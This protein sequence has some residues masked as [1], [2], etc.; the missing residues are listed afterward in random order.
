MRAERA[1]DAPECA[2]DGLPTGIPVGLRTA[3]DTMRLG[4]SLAPNVYAGC[5][6][7]LYGRIGAGKTTLV[8]GLA[9]GLG[10][11][12]AAQSP[13]FTIVAEYTGGR[14][15]LYHIDL[16]RLEEDAARELDMLDEY[17]YGE[18]VCAVEWAGWIE[19]ALPADRLDIFLGDG[20]T[21]RGGVGQEIDIPAWPSGFAGRE[22]VPRG[23]MD[24]RI[25]LL[26]ATG[27][28]SSDALGRWWGAWR[29]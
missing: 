6:V 27:A 11:P 7:A 18:G 26:R 9:H 21:V 2:A 4:E 28:R 22:D 24:S 12:A 20:G 14:L 13:T 8:Q 17:L 16:Y 29:S 23:A 19:A 5:V 10:I 3:H 1:N 15:P 25:A